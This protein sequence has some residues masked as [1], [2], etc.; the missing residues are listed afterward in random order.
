LWLNINF[1]RFQSRKLDLLHFDKPLFFRIHYLQGFVK[2]VEKYF[3]IF[4][5]LKKKAFTG[6]IKVENISSK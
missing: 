4:K 5:L 6:I 1:N 3:N 2:I